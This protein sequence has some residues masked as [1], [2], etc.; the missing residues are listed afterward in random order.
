[1]IGQSL[2]Q[3]TA[4]SVG[5]GPWW[6]RAA[7]GPG[8]GSLARRIDRWR[9]PTYVGLNALGVL[10]AAY[11]TWMTV[12]VIPGGQDAHA[13]WAASL[14]NPYLSSTVAGVDAYLYSPAFLQAL[15]PLRLLPWQPF[16][17][18]VVATMALSVVIAWR[19]LSPLVLLL[20]PIVCQLALGNIDI[21]LGVTVAFGLRW[22]ALWALPLLTKVTPGVGLIWFA[23]R[24]EWRSL[25]IALGVTAGIVLG[26]ALLGGRWDAW[27]EVL[28]RNNT[29]PPPSWV[30]PIP[31]FVRLAGGAVLVAWGGITDRRWTVIL[32]AY[33]ALPSLGYASVAF[34]VG[35]GVLLWSPG[36]GPRRV[37]TRR[38]TAEGAP[39]PAGAATTRSAHP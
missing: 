29:A 8:A 34:L 6:R 39:P 1:M 31:I 24:R 17:A 12:V 10:L 2:H 26:S 22:P 19:S 23:V 20:N 28:T 16:H 11:L 25:A 5:A 30:V 38:H 35:L 4:A 27:L 15:A 3:F 14:S 9:Q 36:A 18:I 33:L 13:Y 32:A 37:P 7:N 21:L